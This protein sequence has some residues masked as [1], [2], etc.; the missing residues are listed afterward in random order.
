MTHLAWDLGKIACKLLSLPVDLFFLYLN[1]FSLSRCDVYKLK[2]EGKTFYVFG[3]QKE[4]RFN[5]V[6]ELL[7]LIENQ[8]RH[9]IIFQ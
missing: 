9:S 6:T 3:A 8:L 4:V 7:Y 5:T 2:F 1:Y